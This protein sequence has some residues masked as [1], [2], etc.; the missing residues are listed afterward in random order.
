M[1]E[2]LVQHGPHLAFV[3]VG[4]VAFFW[5]AYR[6]ER[7]PDEPGRGASIR[8]E[9]LQ[10]STRLPRAATVRRSVARRGLLALGPLLGA[11]ATG[12][13]LYGSDAV[14]GSVPGAVIWAHSGISVLALLL[15]VYKV[16]DLGAA[17][18]RRA[19]TRQRLPELLSLALAALSVPLLITGVG[20]LLAPGT[21]SFLSY[22][23][24]IS[25]AWWTGLM[26]W[27]LRRYLRPSLRAAIPRAPAATGRRDVAAAMSRDAAI[28]RQEAAANG[29]LGV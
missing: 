8:G 6:P 20:L 23:H 10:P 17:G 3:A 28:L 9:E 16:A 2:L 27:H 14:G 24:L 15:V 13:I 5:M 11:V 19:V 1:T 26:L 29:D 18:I 7:R 25:S 21:Q 22:S 12:A 4:V